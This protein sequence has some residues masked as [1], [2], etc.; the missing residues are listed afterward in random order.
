MS[1][2]AEPN[3]PLRPTLARPRRRWLRVGAALV[4]LAAF[5]VG[6][7]VRRADELDCRT[8][9]RTRGDA[10]AVVACEREYVRTGDPAIGGLLADEHRRAGNPAIAAAIAHGLLVTDAR[11]DGLRVLGRIAITEH[12]LDD[13][14]RLLEHARA[15]DRAAGNAAAISRDGQALAGAYN[16]QLRFAEALR[17][18]DEAVAQARAAREPSLE[19]YAHISAARVLHRIGA[20]D[21]AHRAL[22]RAA[23]LVAT[24]RE[25]AWL[26][27]ERGNLLQE[28]SRDPS[29]A[30]PHEAE[31]AAFETVLQL[32]RE[33]Q[34]TQL[35]VSA[36]LN[37]AYSLTE[38]GELDAAER[39]LAAVDQLDVDN[40]DRAARALRRAHIAFKRGDYARAAA[41][42]DP[43]VDQLDDTDDRAEVC[44]TRARIAIAM[45]DDALA[46]RWLQRG[47]A[48]VEAAI[49]AQPPALRAWTR[50]TRREPYELRFALHARAALAQRPDAQRAALD[51]LAAFDAFHG[52]ALLDFAPAR[53]AD[54]LRDIAAQLDRHTAWVP[55]AQ[56]AP[57]IAGALAP[58]A[59]IHDLLALVVAEATVWRITAGADGALAVTEL[60]ALADLQ[61]ALDDFAAH[62]T[63]RRI[64]DA[65]GARLVP[66]ALAQRTD[67]PL[68]VVLDGPLAAL[69][70]AALRIAGAP[71]IAHRP[72]LRAPRL[73]ELACLPGRAA[74]PRTSAVLA[75]ATGDLP[76]ARALAIDVAQ[77]LGAAPALGNAATAR[78]LAVDA[79]LLHVSSHAGIDDDGG[80]LVLADRKLHALE[81]A[82]R[83]RAPDRVVLAACASAR[84]NDL[85]LAGSLATAFLAAGATQ[86][87]ATLRPVSDRGA[88]ALLEQLYAEGGD[89]DPIR[90]LARAQAARATTDDPDWPSFAVFGRDRCVH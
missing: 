43:L 29:T 74:P 16:D 5:A 80:Y 21:A 28:R 37:L 31:I 49:A 33:L 22:E 11:A 53:R 50:S 41:L 90:A 48:E 51:A 89:R 84:A 7:L 35:V 82:G 9:V 40:A 14:T 67:E 68:R 58:G 13:A 61:P 34:V 52:R 78:A 45:R 8:A 30:H 69:P 42:Y 23:P 6:Y 17:A 85:E 27:A 65:L 57:L 15:L 10:V 56:R 87:V 62:P 18:L 25:R 12:R 73:T 26:V 2:R 4:V 46:E 3:A 86:V 72:V 70:V 36:E 44:A 81:L 20:F 38:H 64:A 59:A 76:E 63:D 32:A 47:I 71:L 66:A 24:D 39:H 88:R 75:D 1:L 83:G 60:G 19:V 54:E 79:D 55:D 77:R